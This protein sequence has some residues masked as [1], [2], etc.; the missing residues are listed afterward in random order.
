L[1]GATA[2]EGLT[3][4]LSHFGAVIGKAL[5]PP[6]TESE[7]SADHCEKAVI[8]AQELETWMSTS[9]LL[10]F[11]NI[12][13]KDMDVVTTY[14]ALKGDDFRKV[15]VQDKIDQASG[16]FQFFS[17]RSYIDCLHTFI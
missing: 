9:N 8:R 7:L 11:V 16:L 6:P 15:W 13:K 14:L 17:L 12:L 2:L 4:S 3:A 10:A 1:T 5:A